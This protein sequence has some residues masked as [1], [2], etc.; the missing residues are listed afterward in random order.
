MRQKRRSLIL[1]AILLQFAVAALPSY[2][3]TKKHPRKPDDF[4]GRVC[5]RQ[6]TDKMM[7]MVCNIY[8]EARGESHLGKLAVG[9]TTLTR[10]T[11]AEYPDSIC[12]VVWQNGQFSW[13][14]DRHSNRL[15]KKGSPEFATLKDSVKAAKEV[16]RLGPN[17]LT[18]F[19]NPKKSS[20]PWR[21][22]PVC[23][24]SRKKIGHHYFC[25]LS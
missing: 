12:A 24:A 23:V 15:P 4:S 19:C 2:A 21:N 7:C 1:L 14:A 20:C 9:R 18:N 13:T 11:H 10:I 22:S 25:K 17:G 5:Q 8:F 3:K 6:E 16:F